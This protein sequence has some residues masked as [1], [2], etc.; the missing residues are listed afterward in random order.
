MPAAPPP[1]A[2]LPEP[3]RLIANTP[4]LADTPMPHTPMMAQ[5]QR[6]TFP[7]TQ[8]LEVRAQTAPPAPLS[9]R[10]ACQHMTASE[11]A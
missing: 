9:L 4:M 1:T 5:Y 6:M 2:P 10:V 8:N 7:A 11:G 3:G